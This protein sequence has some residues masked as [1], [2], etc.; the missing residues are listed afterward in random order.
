[1]HIALTAPALAPCIPSPSAQL[2]RLRRALK[3]ANARIA[4]LERTLYVTARKQ[5]GIGAEGGDR[6]ARGHSGSRTG[7]GRDGG[8]GDGNSGGGAGASGLGATPIP[9][10]SPQPSRGR[11]HGAEQGAAS[12]DE[13]EGDGEGDGDGGGGRGGGGGRWARC[14]CRCRCRGLVAHPACPQGPFPTCTALCS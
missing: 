8:G 11:R 2:I 10:G 9:V 5:G 1:M 3:S 13:G 6:P 14:R 12:G 7:T 4:S